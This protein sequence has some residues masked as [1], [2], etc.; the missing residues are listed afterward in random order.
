MPYQNH[1]LT[2][3]DLAVTDVGA[4]ELRTFRRGFSLVDPHNPYF[5]S[6]SDLLP[7]Q[8]LDRDERDLSRRESVIGQSWTFPQR[9]A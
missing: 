7:P 8:F 4:E 9:G 5:D 2:D 6:E 1:S 3:F